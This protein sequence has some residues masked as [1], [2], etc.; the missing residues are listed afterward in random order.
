MWIVTFCIEDVN[1]LLQPNQT[2]NKGRD[3]KRREEKR[4]QNKAWI[5]EKQNKAKQNKT[6]PIGSNIKKVSL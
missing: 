6:A 4:R 3:E 1:S 5:E 2:E